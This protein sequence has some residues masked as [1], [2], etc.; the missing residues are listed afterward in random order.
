MIIISEKKQHNI[1]WNNFERKL[2]TLLNANNIDSYA[3]TPDYILAKFI[4]EI[5]VSTAYFEIRK[6]SHK[7]YRKKQCT[8]KA[9]PLKTKTKKH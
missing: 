4:T 6:A 9:K 1:N 5:I 2:A 7:T 8:T 3:D